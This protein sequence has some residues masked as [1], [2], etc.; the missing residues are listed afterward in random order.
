[1]GVGVCISIRSKLRIKSGDKFISSQPSLASGEGAGIL[2]SL[3]IRGEQCF[4][5]RPN[6]GYHVKEHKTL[7]RNSKKIDPFKAKKITRDE[8]SDLGEKIPSQKMRKAPIKLC[9]D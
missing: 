4:K 9:T 7:C 8:R 3:A 6:N 2:S 5:S 1:M